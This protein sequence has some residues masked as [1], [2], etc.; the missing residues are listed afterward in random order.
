MR[1]DTPRRKGPWNGLL[2]VRRGG[3][4]GLPRTVRLGIGTALVTKG[5]AAP[6]VGAGGPRSVRSPVRR[7]S[8]TRTRLFST[9]ARSVPRA[10]ASYLPLPRTQSARRPRRILSTR[11]PRTA[12]TSKNR[13]ATPVTRYSCLGVLQFP[14]RR[15]LP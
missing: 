6:S 13:R 5:V 8:R 9:E 14:C 1:E 3:T 11:R 12:V 10:P 15:K 2:P 7:R 4:R